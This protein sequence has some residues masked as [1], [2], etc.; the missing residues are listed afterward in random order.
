[1]SNT[2]NKIKRIKDHFRCAKCGKLLAKN[3]TN[4]GFEI[5][6]LRCGN[7]NITFDQMIEQVTITDPDGKILYINKAAE[8]ATGYFQHEVV[9]RKPSEFWGKQ[10]PEIF[11]EKMWRFIKEEK[12]T[13]KTRL[14]NKRKTGEFYEV[15]FAISPILDV[16][17]NIIFYV[18]IEVMVKKS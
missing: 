10:M 15:D 6:C 8:N 7:L 16:K 12:G 18:G 1:M 9:G 5:K 2:P 13:F 17:K 14:L 3:L 4:G 11:Y